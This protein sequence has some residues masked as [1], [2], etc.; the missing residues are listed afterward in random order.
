MK[1][2]HLMKIS[3]LMAEESSYG[4]ESL[5]K[6]KKF[7]TVGMGVSTLISQFFRVL[8]VNTC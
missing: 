7:K 1:S 6:T 3:H 8:D 2:E 4:S 5:L